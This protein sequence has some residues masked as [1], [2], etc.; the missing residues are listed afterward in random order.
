MLTTTVIYTCRYPLSL[1]NNLE[2]DSLPSQVNQTRVVFP[3]QQ[4]TQR[5]P[6]DY[7]ESMISPLKIQTHL[8][9]YWKS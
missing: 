8:Y 7:Q 4:Q 2:N 3:Q 1:N 6:P 5:S 9:E